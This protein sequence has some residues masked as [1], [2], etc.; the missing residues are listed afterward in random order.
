MWSIV[1]QMKTPVYNLIENSSGQ[2]LSSSSPFPPKPSLVPL[3]AEPIEEGALTKGCVP[4]SW[5]SVAIFRWF[6]LYYRRVCLVSFARHVRRCKCHV[7]STLP[8]GA[9][10]DLKTQFYVLFR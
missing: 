10:P 2:E 7:T 6:L 5:R 4:G 9:I 8:E 1:E 3:N